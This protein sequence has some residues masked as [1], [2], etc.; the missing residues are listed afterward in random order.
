LGLGLGSV[1]MMLES[2]YQQDFEYTAI[3][4]DPEVCRLCNQY[5]LQYLDSRVETISADAE[6]FFNVN[7]RKFD[8][9]IMDIFQSAK[10]PYK[11]QSA[12]FI[13]NLRSTLTEDGLL[14][15]NTMNIT[16][17]DKSDYIEL[18][19]NFQ[20]SFPNAHPLKIKQNIVLINDKSYLRELS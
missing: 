3:E 10:I 14:L 20:Q 7:E 18:F 5:T 6:V 13:S 9:I 11:F 12:D 8:F 4:I 16:E 17:D 19:Q 2:I 1:I 15:F